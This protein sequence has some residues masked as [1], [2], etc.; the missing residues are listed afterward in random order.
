MAPQLG[1]RAVG[2]LRMFSKNLRKILLED[3]HAK[4]LQEDILW[5]GE[6]FT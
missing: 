1:Q 3:L 6:L 4:Q 2:K 5:G